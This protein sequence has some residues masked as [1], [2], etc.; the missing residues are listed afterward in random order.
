[1]LEDELEFKVGELRDVVDRMASNYDATSWNSD[2]KKYAVSQSIRYYV[3]QIDYQLTR[4][5]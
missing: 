1:M 5:E 2:A 4:I 3:S